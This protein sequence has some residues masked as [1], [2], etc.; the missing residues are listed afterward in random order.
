MRRTAVAVAVLVAGAVSSVQASGQMCGT[1]SPTLQEMAAVEAALRLFPPGKSIGPVSIPV[2]FHAIHDGKNGKI[3]RGRVD[4]LVANL[5]WA[6][7]GTPFS[8]WL[9]KMDSTKNKAWYQSRL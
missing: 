1:P 6:F 9:Y 8:F 3:A 2:A 4:V 5:N 7:R